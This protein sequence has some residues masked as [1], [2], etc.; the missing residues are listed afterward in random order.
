IWIA[1]GAVS[2]VTGERPLGTPFGLAAAAIIGSLNAYLN[3]IAWL[4]VRRAAH[5]DRSLL[6]Q[7][8]LRARSVQLGSSLFVHVTMT[9]AALSPAH[10]IVTW[11]D[12]TGALFVACFL[13]FNAV[14]ML[15]AGIPDI[16]DRSAGKA[17][18]AGIERALARHA[19]AFERLHRVRS[20]RA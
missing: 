12:A 16:I 14:E 13:S 2:M 3:L 7:G 6:M 18:R 9:I 17:I 5:A 15:R 4:A 11:A 20:R 8:Q 1:F 19:G 10:V